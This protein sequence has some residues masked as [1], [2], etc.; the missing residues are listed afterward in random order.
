MHEKTKKGAEE[1]GEK[2][3][4]KGLQIQSQVGFCVR[5]GSVYVHTPKNN[6]QMMIN[7]EKETPA[8]ETSAHESDK[9]QW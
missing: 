1:E 7:K 4:N 5:D 2:S 6:C 8:K 9:C 3:T